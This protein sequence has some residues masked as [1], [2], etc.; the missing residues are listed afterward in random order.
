MT[1]FAITCVLALFASLSSFATETG[2]PSWQVYANCAAAYRANWQNRLAG[3]NRTQAMS[4]MIQEQSGDYQKAAS[5][6][7]E[8]ARKVSASAAD[9]AVRAY[10]Q[11]NIVGY[12][13]MDKAGTL[14]SF[15]DKCPQLAP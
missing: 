11:A 15:I 7:Y 2:S 12:V 3:P 14:E 9:Q 13:A 6:S 10:M 5:R 4:A 1:R 8:A